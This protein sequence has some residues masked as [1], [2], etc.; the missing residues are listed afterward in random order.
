MDHEHLEQLARGRVWTGA[1]A[2]ER[3]LVDHV[4]GRT[5]AVERACALADVDRKR[6]KVVHVGDSG[7]LALIKPATSSEAA[8]GTAGLPDAEGLLSDLARRAG[9]RSDGVLSLPWQLR[10]R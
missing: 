10:V 7:I 3:G 8:A 1:D 5:L 2:K 9:L 4:G 6:A